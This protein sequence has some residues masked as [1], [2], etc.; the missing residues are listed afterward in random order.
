MK[1]SKELT[2]EERET[3]CKRLIKDF[4][5]RI[6]LVI[7]PV[8]II[9]KWVEEDNL[10]LLE[11]KYMA[12][13]CNNANNYDIIV[14]DAVNEKQFQQYIPFYAG[15]ELNILAI[16]KADKLCPVVSA[17]SI[18]AKVARDNEI[19]KL[20]KMYG[21]FGSGYPSDEKTILFIEQLFRKNTV[22][23]SYIRKTWSTI[24]KKEQ[25]TLEEWLQ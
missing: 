25:S 20:K 4:K 11:C 14:V 5:S 23:P 19:E 1:D 7:I 17:A 24:T 10:N 12:D 6:I 18:V 8:E 13:I 3:I 2:K 22:L 16:N 21:D 9:D 15:R